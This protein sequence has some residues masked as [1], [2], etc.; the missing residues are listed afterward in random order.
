[1]DNFLSRGYGAIRFLGCLNQRDHNKSRHRSPLISRSRIPINID[2]SLTVTELFY[3]NLVEHLGDALPEGTWTDKETTALL[4]CSSIIRCLTDI[5]HNAENIKEL[6][7]MLASSLF[8]KEKPLQLRVKSQKSVH[9][10]LEHLKK[11]RNV[12]ARTV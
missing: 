3:F 6:Y 5:P 7:T 10:K 8:G 2:S 11:M 12:Y 9:Q 4:C 1:M